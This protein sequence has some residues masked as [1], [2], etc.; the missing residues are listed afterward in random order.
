MSEFNADRHAYP[1]IRLLIGGR[2][3]RGT[4]TATTEIENPATG[5]VLGMVPHASPADLDT[6]AAAAAEGFRAW[7]RTPVSARGRVLEKARAL[8]L[9][10][11]E[12]IAVNMTREQGKPFAQARSEVQSAADR[13]RRDVA[14]AQR[15]YGQVIP[16]EADFHLF[17]VREP[18]GPVAAF[19]PWN[20]PAGSPMRKLAAALASGCSIVLKA[21]EETPAT[22]MALVECLHAAGLPDGVVNLVFGEPAAIS[23]HLIAHPA[24]R[25]ATFTGS[26]PVGKLIA[27]QA[28]EGVKPCL[29]ELGGHAP[30][31][32][33]ADFDPALA[34]RTI[35]K[36]KFTN[37]GQV[38]TAPSRIMVHE[39]IFDP[40]VAAFVETA[41][42]LRLGN[43]LDADSQVGPL[44]NARR[45]A[46]VEE[47]IADAVARGARVL[48]GGE[49]IDG[50]GHFFAPTV[51]VE[52]PEDARMMVEEPFGPVAP[53]APFADL[54]EAIA[55]ANALPYGLAAYG[56]TRDSR[57][58]DRLWRGLEA[59]MLSINH[60][61]G[62]VHEAP[63]GG[64]KE[65]GYGREGGSMA[66]DS[67]LVTKRVSHRL[68]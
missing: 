35:A 3:T 16:Y 41:Q 37:A 47:M 33:A 25:M 39:A 1:E 10:R 34:A 9:D 43:G 53:I 64:V 68:V 55:R 27:R 6:A 58:A 4:G 49:R 40:F 54:D 38:C 20:F 56:F 7:S 32:V 26:V 45:L 24:I 29:L 42:A 48:C 14:E 12:E 62:S 5:E 65:S 30:V 44:A 13:L 8:I 52:V 67:Y 31:I 60:T 21:S 59:G 18:I 51:L 11:A 63:T 23:A 50:P 22:A 2:W 17:T 57:T 15:A 61:G 19:S 36:S 46:A 28:A 66:L